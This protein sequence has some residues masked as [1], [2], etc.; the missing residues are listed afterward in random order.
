M[1]ARAN[2]IVTF[3]V[4]MATNLANGSFNP[5]A[6]AG[7]GTDGVYVRGTFDGWASPGMQLFEVGST[8]V[9]TNSYNDTGDANG[10][11]VTYLYDINGNDEGTGDYDNRSAYLPATSGASLA[12][13]TQFY[14]DVGPGSA[15]NV[16]FQV[17]MSEEIELGHFNPKNGDTVVI[18]GSFNGWSPTAGSQY[19]LTNNPNVLVTNYN[20]A[21]GLVESNVYTVTVPI[22]SNSEQP[23]LPATNSLEEWKY[24][25]DP[26]ENWESPGPTT[27]DGNGNRFFVAN[28][29]QTLP[30]V[31]FDD[32]VYAPLAQ[33]ALSVDMSAVLRY[34]TNYVPG[35]VSVWGTFNNYANGI[36]LTN[37]PAAANPNL[38]SGATTMAEGVGITYQFRYTNSVLNGWVYD[39]TDDQVF[40]NNDR[41]YLFLPVTATL[42][43][44][45]LPAV[46]FNDLAVNDVLPVATPVQFS[47]N[48]SGAVGT[49]GHVFDP[50]SDGVYLNGE[51]ANS[52]G[53]P[54]SWYPWSGG[55]NPIPAPSGFQMIEVGASSVYTNTIV[56]AA[57]NP[58]ALSYQYGLDPG[59]GNGGPLED[60]SASGVNHYRVVRSTGFNPYVLPVDTFTNQPYN[61]P[62]FSTGNI[63][64]V[65][66]LSGG[67]LTVGAASGGKVPVSWLGRPW[68][69]F[70]DC[71]QSARRLAE[72]PG[73][74]WY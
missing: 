48:M 54:Q 40:N 5:P 43:N 18:A 72:S 60:E 37:N 3:S 20:F 6:P 73:D 8:A 42:L 66:S 55:V 14:N 35:S 25:E 41:R 27:A 29:N 19:V 59:Q 52:G 62:I 7:S 23:G 11:T 30:L 53:Y 69:A 12:L 57:G 33:V 22:A 39:F 50:S 10:N 38:F 46:Y 2:T 56:I 74:G 51:F 49:D 9:Y 70:A 16:T 13:P 44:T 26:S 1:T 21:G 17:D 45:N 63:N 34:D 36:A 65:G 64:G 24:V 28:T 15:L 67:N 31:S 61:E 58:V 47:V 32:E 4:D 68:R 71:Q